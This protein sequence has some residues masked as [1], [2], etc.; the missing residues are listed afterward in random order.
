MA[1]QGKARL[2]GRGEA[3]RGLARRGEARLGGLGMAG[4]VAAGRSLTQ[5]LT[6]VPSAFYEAGSV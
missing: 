6:G 5:R 2:G 4:L 3:G 1:W